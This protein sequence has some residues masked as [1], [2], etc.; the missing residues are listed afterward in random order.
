MIETP[1]DF[2]NDLFTTD[3]LKNISEE[4]LFNY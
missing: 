4:S 3:L 2:L 1:F